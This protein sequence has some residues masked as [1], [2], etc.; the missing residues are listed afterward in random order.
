[1]HHIHYF[2]SPTDVNLQEPPN[3]IDGN[4]PDLP[5]RPQTTTSPAVPPA[6]SP[7]MATVSEQARMLK[8]YEDQQAALQAQREAEE[9]QRQE[10]QA[11]QQLEFEQR[12]HEQQE[13][14]RLAQEQLM[15]Q[16]MMQMNSQAAQQLS[17]YQ[18][19]SLAMRGQFERDQLLLEQYDRVC[20]SWQSLDRFTQSESF[21]IACEST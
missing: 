10:L 20:I 21:A 11:Q 9:R 13:R 5:P 16:Q 2:I 18:R 7:D 17:E 3:L 12:Q 6:P 4:A 1:M 15:Q 19:E 14:E 8:Q